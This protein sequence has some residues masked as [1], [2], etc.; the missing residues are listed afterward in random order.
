[1]IADGLLT[2]DRLK[3]LDKGFSL[4]YRKVGFFARIARRLDTVDDDPE[5]GLHRAMAASTI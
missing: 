4:R 1:M 5:H 3:A 2:K